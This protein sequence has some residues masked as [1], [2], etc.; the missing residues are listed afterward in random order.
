MN[1]EKVTEA[2][3]AAVVAKTGRHLCQVETVLLRGACQGKTYEQMAQ[4]CQYSL[5]YLKQAAGPKLW[6]LLSEVLGEEVSKT[7]F[8]V[9]LERQWRFSFS[10]AERKATRSR[11][12]Q[13]EEM[14]R[15]QDIQSSLGATDY[16]TRYANITCQSQDW[17][18]APD[19]AIFYGRTKELATLEQWIVKERC[20]LVAIIGMGGIGKTTLSVRCAKQLQDEF[21]YIIWRSLRHAPSL[22]EI[23]TDLIQSLSNQQTTYLQTD[24]DN[25]VSLLI[26]YLQRHRCLLVLDS[27]ETI[28]RPSELAGYYRKEHESYRGLLRRI[29]E[30]PH[31]SCL[32]LTSQEKPREIAA[33]SG[34]SLPVRSLHLTGL[35]ETE[36]REIFKE[37]SLFEWGKWGEL[38]QLY[39]GNPLALKIVATTI[40]EL[41][42]GHVDE[43]LKQDTIVFGDIRDIL[44]EQFERLS[45]LEMEILYW[46]AIECKPISLSKLPAI[47][48]SPVSPSELIEAL[49]SLRRRSLI[50]RSTTGV[51]ALLVLQQPVI[52]EYVTNQFIKQVSEEIREVLKTQKIEKIE[53]L[54]NHALV[55]PQ[56][57]D[58][59]VKKLQRR[60]ILTPVKSRLCNIFRDE[61]LIEEQL[62]KVLSTLQGKS[63]LAVG[64]ARE[65]IQN[66]LS[67][68]K[69]DLS[70]HDFSYT[71]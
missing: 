20:R 14:L 44:D 54:R 32:V 52:T 23:L 13:I 66:L 71:V 67:E 64:Y 16:P 65:N 39:R 19:V 11:T 36:A 27:V 1:L 59:S 40:Q 33:L 28:L 55:N 51:T 68:I 18:E 37:K 17:G 43:F 9:I 3:D 7:N 35:Q 62:T 60:F 24:V 45:A 49:E 41:F 2:V 10:D 38:I 48:L 63:P 57:Q 22:A 26:D 34:K 47:I 15:P 6:K 4:T 8:R 42:G 56:E 29:I 46:L 21:E 30:T 61:R 31:Q 50:E 12:P 58:E 5:T 25:K 70:S 69:A 53:L